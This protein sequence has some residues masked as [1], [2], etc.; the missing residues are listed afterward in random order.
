MLH[1]YCCDE[2]N[3]ITV[4]KIS[5]STLTGK[6]GSHD[7]ILMLFQNGTE[8]MTTNEAA[9]DITTRNSSRQKV[10]HHILP[11]QTV[12]KATNMG[13]RGEISKEFFE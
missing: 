2:S 11:C 12:S 13:K 6:G 7:T 9:V 10:L 5:S 4:L 1:F 8:Q 3:Q